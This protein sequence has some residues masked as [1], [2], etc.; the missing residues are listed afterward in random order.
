M[1]NSGH[2]KYCPNF[3]K[4]EIQEC[5]LTLTYKEKFG[6]S[7]RLFT[8]SAF[9]YTKDFV[10]IV[11]YNAFMYVFIKQCFTICLVLTVL[12]SRS[13]LYNAVL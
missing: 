13:G 12:Y 6:S 11:L 10:V 3:D 8:A 5:Y 9:F 2:E 7:Q 1:N 4:K